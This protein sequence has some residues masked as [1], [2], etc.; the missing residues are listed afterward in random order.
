MKSGPRIVI[1]GGGSNAWTPNIVKDMLLTPSLTEAEYVLFD[2]NKKPA[3]TNKAF[4]EKLC[5]EL[6]IKP[7]ITATDSRV[8]ALRGADYIIITVS[9]GG[10]NAMAHD[11]A[12]PEDYGIYHTVGDT[13]GPGGWARLMRNFEVF[14]SLA[15]D[16]KRY[17]PNALVLN[18]T[19]PMVS[20]TDVMARILP[21]RVVGL[22]HGLFENINFIKE[23]Y[24]LDSEEEIAVKYAG[25]NHFFWITEAK[26]G[27]V[28]VLA[29]LERRLRRKSLTD[30][31]Q[32]AYK[33]AMG[34]QSMNREVATELFH[35]TGVIPYVGD[36]HTCEYF[37]RYITSKSV[38]KT[39]KIKRT[40]VA[41][42]RTE[43]NKRARRL[44]S[45]LRGKIDPGY[46]KRSRETAADI[47]D[48][49]FQGKV[50]I[51]VGNLPNTGQI[52]NLPH[53]AVV[54]TAVRV[55]SNGFSPVGFGALPP[56]VQAMCEPWVRA[57]TMQVDACFQG[58]KQLAMQALLIDPLCAHLTGKQ[59]TEMGNRLLKA[60]KRFI[61]VF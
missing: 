47:I 6:G 18:Y 51:D 12:I 4:L 19:N 60:H 54:E 37:G 9:T 31:M 27:G 33:D 52:S 32:M 17:A 36:R 59:V 39:Y 38:M 1:V 30:L 28:D 22:C 8:K 15:N 26:A 2:I 13:T 10:L 55:D 7:R 41:E 40:S 14:Q 35:L 50:F 45:M 5:G 23:F 24:K 43:F 42:R 48:A 20:L 3:D 16:I 21:G 61:T 25:L 44:Q 11:L 53:G 58:D 49:H 34:F 56:V 57:Y 29:D 46:T